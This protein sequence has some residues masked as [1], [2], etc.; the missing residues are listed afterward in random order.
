MTDMRQYEQGDMLLS[1]LLPANVIKF[2]TIKNAEILALALLLI[3][4][5][6]GLFNSNFVNIP[7]SLF[8]LGGVALGLLFLLRYIPQIIATLLREWSTTLILIIA[9]ASVFWSLAPSITLEA[10]IWLYLTTFVGVYIAL[11]FS[12]EEQL[13]LLV[14]FSLLALCISLFF[15]FVMPSVGVHSSGPHVGL[16]RGVFSHKNIFS[17]YLVIG[18]IPLIL[19][20]NRIGYWR[21]IFAALLM[22]GMWGASSGTGLV[23]T[24]VMVLIFPLLR[25]LRRRH[26]L[27]VATALLAIPAAII[28]LLLLSNN[29]VVL[30][31]SVGEDATLSGRTDLWAAAI[32]M[33]Q[34][35]PFTGWGFQAAFSDNSP[36]FSMIRWQN[37]PFAHNHWLDLTLELGIFAT[38]AYAFALILSL[39]RAIVYIRKQKSIESFYPLA[40]L[41]QANILALATQSLVGTFDVVWIMYVAVVYSLAIQ[42]V[43]ENY[44]PFRR[45]YNFQQ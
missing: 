14:I 22:L 43:P 30:L 33:I 2:F 31:E 17:R 34:R 1:R 5:S 38:I 23:V 6:N 20:G 19:L 8:Q 41:I 7:V 25:L 28:V 12:P 36:V 29:Y 4:I 24:F 15:I 42:D 45:S 35:R 27:I 9:G 32:E 39:G 11:R 3:F 10:V 16:W 18:L 13:W 21:W 26:E 37:A 44:L 40:Y